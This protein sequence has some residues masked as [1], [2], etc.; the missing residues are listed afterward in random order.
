MDAD[1]S[2]YVGMNEW[3]VMWDAIKRMPWRARANARQEVMDLYRQSRPWAVRKRAVLARAGGRCERCLGAA[4][5]LVIHHLNYIRRFR[6]EL[7]D[8]LAICEGCHDYV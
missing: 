1:L 7:T 4:P 2:V 3:E 8:L 5:R 6:E